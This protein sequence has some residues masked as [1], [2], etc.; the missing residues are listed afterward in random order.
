MLEALRNASKNWLGKIVLTVMFSLLILSFAIWGIGDIFRGFGSGTVAKAGPVEVSTEEYRAEYQTMLQ[1]LQR[2]LG[3]VVTNDQARKEGLDRLVLNRMISEGLI[4]EK[5]KAM[6]LAMN[7]QAIAK[8][9]LDDPRFRGPTGQ[10]DRLAFQRALSDNGLN[11]QRFLE[12]QREN[13]LRQQL[14]NSFSGNVQIPR[15]VLEIWHRMGTETRSVDF[16]TLTG[17]NAGAIPTPSDK[18]LNAFY[19]ARKP[20]YRAPEYR[21]IVTLAITPDKVAK[22]DAITDDEALKLY[23]SQKDSKYTELEKREVQQI[24]FKPGEDSQAQEA[25]KKIRGGAKFV[26]VATERKLTAAD[27]NLGTLAEKDFVDPA[28]AKSA[29]AIKA[30]ETSD[31]VKSRF[32]L[33]LV[34]V[35]SVQAKTVKA[36]DA[37]KAELKKELAAKRANDDIRKIYEKIEDQRTSGKV[38]TEAAKAAG[39]TVRTIDAIDAAGRDKAGKDVTDIVEKESFL[40]TVF[41]SDIGVDNDTITVRSGGYVWFE[42]AAIDAARDRK[43]EE[44]RAQVESAWKAVEISKKLREM[45]EGYVKAIE[46]GKT[47]A[48]V[49]KEA[50]LTVTSAPDVK[51]GTHAKLAA[52]VV[53]RI[54][55]LP[56]GKPGTAVGNGLE[57]VVFVINDANVPPLVDKGEEL[58]RVEKSLQNAY[59][60]ELFEQYVARLRNGLTVTYNPVAIRNVVGGEAN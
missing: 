31:V 37:V 22:P 9:V 38:L 56:V 16:F 6:G 53:N 39:Y 40:R 11:E 29:F 48:D 51:R 50:K 21:K 52:G 60:Q 17:A 47:I 42:V 44:V 33:A 24:I 19:E 59:Q 18:D 45:G 43:L 3:R 41:E 28:I 12:K 57:R 2:Q 35:V 58:E 14:G 13:Y 36:F 23:E 4:D 49:A 25:L 5:A 10:F 27:I 20:T 1:N 15:A 55:S 32:G 26:D 54:F 7:Y 46:S 8:G 30:G 34:H